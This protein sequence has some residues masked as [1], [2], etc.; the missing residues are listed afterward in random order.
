M[1]ERVTALV[2]AAAAA[3]AALPL[4][5]PDFATRVVCGMKPENGLIHSST[6]PARALARVSILLKGDLFKT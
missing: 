2:R 6:S 1:F 5:F 4:R 3:V